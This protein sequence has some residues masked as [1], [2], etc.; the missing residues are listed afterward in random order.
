MTFI[1]VVAI[2]PLLVFSGRLGN[3]NESTDSPTSETA[4]G[5]VVVPSLTQVSPPILPETQVRLDFTATAE[6]RPTHT[7]TGIHTPT[8]TDTPTETPDFDATYRAEATRAMGT[9]I[10]EWTLTPTP[11]PLQAA[12]D[13]ARNF[14]GSND[15]WDPFVQEF[16]GVEM[17]L[18]PAGCFMMGS[19]DGGSNE[20]PVHEVCFNE[21][22][23]IDQTEVTRVQY[24]QCVDAGECETTPDSNYYSAEPDQPINRVTWFQAEAYCAWRDA[25]LPTEAEWEYA[26]RG[27][28]ALVYPWGDEFVSSYVVWSENSGNETAPVGSNPAGASWVGALDMSGNVWEWTSTIYEDYPYNAEDGREQDTGD[29]ADVRRV[30]RGGSFYESTYILRA[31]DRYG[32]NPIVT[33]DFSGFR[34]A[35]SLK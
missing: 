7:P 15:D 32:G 8:M 5:E 24:Q 21:P 16:D 9:V 12:L 14:N 1:A 23:W 26:A 28:D 6:A 4:V 11:D 35:R 19:E 27:P 34:C 20:Q 18:V 10:A 13:R 3:G 22:F 25:R 30:L 29:S 31:A 2:A 33:Y 17:V